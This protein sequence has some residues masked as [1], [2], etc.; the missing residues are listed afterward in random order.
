MGVVNIMQLISIHLMSIYLKTDG[1]TIYYEST[2]NGHQI[3]TI[4]CKY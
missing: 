4:L 2:A 3:Y 1:G